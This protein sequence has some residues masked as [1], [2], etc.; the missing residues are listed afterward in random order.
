[1]KNGSAMYSSITWANMN[2]ISGL[3]MD[4]YPNPV[5]NKLI[6]LDLGGLTNSNYTLQLLDMTGRP[7][8]RQVIAGIPTLHTSLSLPGYIRSGTYFLQLVT[9]SGDKIAERQ[10]MVQ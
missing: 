3:V 8:L 2:T 1:M 7:V 5:K 9:Q 4:V 10:L 6:F